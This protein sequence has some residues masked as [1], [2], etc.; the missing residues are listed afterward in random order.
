MAAN[1]RPGYEEVSPQ[2]E[3]DRVLPLIKNVRLLWPISVD[4]YY[5]E[6]AE[7]AIQAGATMINDIKGL[8]TP[9]MAEVLAQYPEVQVVIM[10]SRKHQ[11]LSLKSCTNFIQ[12]N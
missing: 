6:V 5:P 7:A 11:S 3:A 12:K 9:G 8:D 2:V 10:H 1:P 4:T